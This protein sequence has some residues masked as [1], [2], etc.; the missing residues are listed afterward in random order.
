MAELKQYED[1]AALV[2]R[3]FMG[4]F[5][6][7]IRLFHGDLLRGDGC[8][9]GRQGLPAPALLAALAVIIELG[10]GLLI[11]FGYRLVA[12]GCTIYVLMAAIIAHRNFGDPNQMSHF[13]KNM[14]IVGGF[15][16]LMVAGPGSYSVDGRRA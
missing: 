5:F 14:A 12:L 2:A 13:W 11:L 15:V 3:L 6:C 10:G 8:R 7:V 4:A 1:L 9:H 16:A